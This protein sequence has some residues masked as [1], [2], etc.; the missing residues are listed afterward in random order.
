MKGDSNNW[1]YPA[2]LAL[3]LLTIVSIPAVGG[4][5]Q[6]VLGFAWI[7]QFGSGLGDGAFGVVADDIGVYLV[8]WTRGTLFRQT[9]AG[10][11]DTFLR[12]YDA[13]GSEVWTRQFGSPASD[14]AAAIALQASGVYIVGE[15]QGALPNQ[16]HAGGADTFVRKYDRDGNE[17]WTRQFGTPSEE[18]PY[19]IAADASGVYVS[20]VTG[21]TL[22]NQT[23]Q[24]GGDA[25]VRKYDSEGSELWTRQFGSPGDE[26]AFGVAAGPSGVYAV[27]E[28]RGENETGV[29]NRDA[30]IQKFDSQGNE[31][32]SQ[33]FG[34]A[35]QRGDERA[36]DAIADSTGVYVVGE[37]N[38]DAFVHKYDADGN[39]LWSDQFGTVRHYARGV[40]VYGPWVF[41]TGSTTGEVGRPNEDHDKDPWIRKY[42]LEGNVVWTL[43]FGNSW[44]EDAANSVF[45]GP[46]GVYVAGATSGDLLDR[47]WARD[48]DAFLVRVGETPDSPVN[49]R[50][51][52]GDG[53]VDLVWDP[54]A[55]DGHLPVTAYRI[56]RGTN[57]DALAPFTVVDG[58]ARAY[59]DGFVLNNVSYHYRVAA[60]NAIGE[61]PSS[62]PVEATPRPPPILIVT[63]Q[64]EFVTY[65]SRVLIEGRTE[66]DATITVSGSPVPVAPDGAFQWSGTLPDGR[67]EIHI[68]AE[69]TI[70]LTS[71]T[72]VTI[73]VDT[74]TPL[75]L[76]VAAATVAAVL[77]LV[78]Y[79]RWARR[80]GGIPPDS[81]S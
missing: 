23:H 17:L 64:T 47:W 33:R 39:L 51:T 24:G 45:A 56:Y 58:S 22:P 68:V 21:G 78:A 11:A 36:S 10:S 62:S 55:F 74:R 77:L 80:S 43:Q 67:H 71:S 9:S 61:G 30:F 44:V 19:D 27:G 70:G 26:W 13:T 79:W 12:K 65:N 54:P 16:T 59:V 2:L 34:T 18:I 57:S 29:W 15:T 60:V 49:L 46:Q 5:D 42:D 6:R 35:E 75:L 14:Q 20:G 66:A 4:Q 32:W 63:T 25:F 50:S 8:G 31:L 48:F 7:D 81:E 73:I 3:A 28:V 38:S 69:N 52:P 76:G 1:H 53:Q 37:M 40:A 41:V 72:T